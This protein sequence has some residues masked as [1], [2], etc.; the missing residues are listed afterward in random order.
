MESGEVKGHITCGSDGLAVQGHG[1]GGSPTEEAD[2]ATTHC[3]GCS[4]AGL[5]DV[6]CLQTPLWADGECAETFTP[7]HA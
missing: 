2:K 7:K 1:G 4:S 5:S 3:Q 6:S